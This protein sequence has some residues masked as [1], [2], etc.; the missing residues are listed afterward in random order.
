MKLILK[1][2]ISYVFLLP[3][4]LDAY[5]ARVS[6]DDV[7]GVA[8]LHKE[9]GKSDRKTAAASY[10]DEFTVKGYRELKNNDTGETFVYIIELDPQ[11]FIAVSVDDN[12]DPV[13]AYSFNSDF[14][15]A[16]SDEN[17]LLEMLTRDMSYRLQAVPLMSASAL[18]ENKKLWDAY[19]NGSYLKDL[20]AAE[21]W[22]SGDDSGWLDTTWNQGPPY[23][24]LCPLDG[25]S[26]SVVGCVATAMSQIVYFHKY[27]K[28][29]SFG[30]SDSYTT[31]TRGILVNSFDTVNS[32]L[33]SI[34]YSDTNDIPALCFACGIIVQ[35]DYTATS[36]AASFDA[37]DF[38]GKLE[39]DDAQ[40]MLGS[41]SS[42]FEVLKEDMKSRRP[43]MLAIYNGSSGHAIV[44]DGYRSTDDY[45][46]NYGWGSA[47]PDAITACW[48][49]LPSGM[50][51]GYSVIGYGVLKITPPVLNPYNS[52]S[53]DTVAYPNPFKPSMMTSTRI[54]MPKNPDGLI[55][56]VRIYNTVGHMVREL[57]G[58][59]LY[60]D[61]D[62][63]NESGELC[64]TGLYY[65]AMKTTEDEKIRGKITIIR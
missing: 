30:A 61:W 51:A 3:L 15:F 25:A 58:G 29:L 13:I 37:T 16:E 42:F 24:D 59:D 62:G 35:M 8:E 38:T 1:F 47:T 45:H 44:A 21:Q 20:T 52:R 56:Y 50:P 17:L 18:D 14:N 46:L 6:L 31:A 65:Y 22:P 40:N 27:P 23:N 54:V 11:G 36:S 49:S 32:Y 63:K 2:I 53:S 4:C 48:Y 26:R 10:I 5:A 33:S 34:D 28:S 39:Y 43:A 7:M 60:V 41:D 57:D 64:A 19:L 9:I 55:E 12:I